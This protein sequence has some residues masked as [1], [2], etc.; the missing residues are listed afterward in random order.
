MARVMATAVKQRKA[1]AKKFPTL[2]RS[3]RLEAYGHC[4]LYDHTG[5]ALQGPFLIASINAD[6][7]VIARPYVSGGMAHLGCFVDVDVNQLVLL[8]TK[9]P[10]LPGHFNTPKGLIDVELRGRK[11]YEPIKHD[12]R[13]AACQLPN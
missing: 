6:R 2:E 5:T 8:N 4:H 10:T 11:G 3:L 13:L 9:P 1:K 12:G 7:A